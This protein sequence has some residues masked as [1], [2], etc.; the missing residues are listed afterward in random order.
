MGGMTVTGGTQS[1]ESFV[2]EIREAARDREV[3]AFTFSGVADPTMFVNL[4]VGEP[5]PAYGWVG[6]W[7]AD[8][9]I[10]DGARPHSVIAAAPPPEVEQLRQL[11]R[12]SHV[13]SHVREVE[14]D[15]FIVI[16]TTS[17]SEVLSRSIERVSDV[18]PLLDRWVTLATA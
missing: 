18:T 5:G 11:V 15:G 17:R 3:V 12:R 14:Q 1:V 6:V 4:P 9:G 7:D 8:D 13:L 2:E 10:A 16:I